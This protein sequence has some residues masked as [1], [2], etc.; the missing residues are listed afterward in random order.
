MN[1]V[2]ER[3]YDSLFKEKILDNPFETSEINDKLN[4]FTDTYLN[5]GSY[6]EKFKAFDELSNLNFAIQR[7]A[8]AVG[9]HTAVE[10]LT[11]K[12]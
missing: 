1:G 8:F 7:N 5:K 4:Q 6:D 11:E 9:F 2:L 12:K 10:L 3:I